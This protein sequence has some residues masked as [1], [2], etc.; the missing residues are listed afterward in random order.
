MKRSVNHVGQI[1]IEVEDWI[2]EYI[3]EIIEQTETTVD[4]YMSMIIKNDI[5]TFLPFD[6]KE[7]WEAYKKAEIKRVHGIKLD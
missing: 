5:R 6:E 7:L 4:E 2:K 1:S 3:D